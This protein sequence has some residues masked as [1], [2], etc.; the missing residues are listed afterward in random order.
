MDAHENPSPIED[1]LAGDEESGPS[2]AQRLKFALF[3]FIL[4]LIV[5]GGVEVLIRVANL[6]Q[7]E[8]STPFVPELGNDFRVAH[9]GDPDL[10]WSLRPN[11]STT[12]W[13]TPVSTN[14]LGLRSEA[15]S[16]KGQNEFRIL[17]LGESSTFGAGVK[18]DESYSVLLERHLNAAGSSNRFRVI[19]A[20]VSAYSS[21]QSTRYLELR[22]LDLQPDMVIIYHELADFLPTTN[23]EG[24]TPDGVGLPLSDKQLFLSQRHNV[25]RLLL[26]RSAIFRFLNFRLVKLKVNAMQTDDA[27]PVADHITVPKQ[28]QSI[29]TPEGVLALKLPQRVTLEEREENLDTMRT[30]CEKNGVQFVVIHPSYGESK[31]HECDL[32]QYCERHDTPMFE[33]YDSLHPESS[34]ENRYGDLWHPN[35]AGHSALAADLFRFLTEHALVPVDPGN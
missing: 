15:I 35:V 12:F 1:Q 24:L 20:G 8:L 21:F 9:R 32:T 23:R 25:N 30:L 27:I 4:A 22:G 28:L 33:A 16:E 34:D 7:P 29:S 11:L 6:D 3:S 31:R 18:D 13:G 17:C 5:L 10:F 19:N 14:A 26:E 2:W